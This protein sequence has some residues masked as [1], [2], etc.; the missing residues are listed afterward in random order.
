[1]YEYHGWFTFNYWQ[2]LEKTDIETQLKKINES[3]PVCIDVVN[4]QLHISISGNPNRDIGYVKEIL[5]YLVGLNHKIYGIIYIND[6]FSKNSDRFEV[7]KIVMDKIT[8]LQDANFSLDETRILF[9]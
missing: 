4:G 7:V 9:N 8:Y 2:D 3:Y 6:S 1:M 5:N